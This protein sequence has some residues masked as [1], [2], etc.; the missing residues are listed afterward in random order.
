[1]RDMRRMGHKPHAFNIPC[2]MARH[3]LCRRWEYMT[4]T[5]FKEKR[6]YLFKLE[7]GLHAWQIIEIIQATQQ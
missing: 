7:T 4:F 5:L 3:H 2:P 6:I 1:M